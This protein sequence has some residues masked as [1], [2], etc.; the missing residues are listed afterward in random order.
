M[1]DEEEGGGEPLPQVAEQRQDLLLDDVVEIGGGLVG[2]D[3]P[4]SSATT[5]AI[6][7]RCSMPPES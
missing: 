7:A 3:Q 4:G 5:I 1:R 6:S 2:N